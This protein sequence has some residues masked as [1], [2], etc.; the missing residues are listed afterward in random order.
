[1]FVLIVIFGVMFISHLNNMLFVGDWDFWTDWKDR[2]W[3]PFLTP[4]ITLL[5]VAIIQKI[6]WDELRLPIGG[7]LVV[8]LM[9]IGQWIVRLTSWGMWV[10]Y[11]VNFVWPANM[12]VMGVMIDL[13]LFWTR[14]YVLT[15]FLGPFVFGLFFVPLQAPA[16]SSF[17]QP[18][19]W[20]GAL[21][22]LADVQGYMYPRGNTPVY[23]RIIESGHFRAFLQ[24]AQYVVAFFAGFAGLFTY[25][26]GSWIAKF[27]GQRSRHVFFPGWGGKGYG[28]G[29]GTRDGP[30]TEHGDGDGGGRESVMAGDY[31]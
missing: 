16:L 12:V 27:F 6:A 23:L 17:Q 21:L 9:V 13:I 30:G 20:H 5:P 2:Q 10:Y 8:L 4:V 7:T 28:K 29:M 11:P 3:W 25:A 19:M 18:V 26:L 15:S 31:L 1:M 22:S 24:Q 14:S